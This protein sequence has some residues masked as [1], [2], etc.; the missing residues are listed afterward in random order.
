MPAYSTKFCYMEESSAPLGS[1][2][3]CESDRGTESPPES[4]H[5]AHE[6]APGFIRVGGVSSC[7]STAWEAEAGE[8]S[9]R[10]G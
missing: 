4:T 6:E 7:Q 5:P 10:Q 1:S 2:T 8:S 3:H 9:L